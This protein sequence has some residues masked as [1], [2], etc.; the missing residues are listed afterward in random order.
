MMADMGHQEPLKF[1][2]VFAFLGLGFTLSDNG[3]NWLGILGHSPI[4]GWP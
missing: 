2:A 1:L 4:G 3:I